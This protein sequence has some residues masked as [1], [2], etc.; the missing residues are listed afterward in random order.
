MNTLDSLFD[1]IFKNDKTVVYGNLGRNSLVLYDYI[2]KEMPTLAIQVFS[3]YY[4]FPNTHTIKTNADSIEKCDL[5]IYIEPPKNFEI[6]SHKHVARIVLFTSHLLL[7]DSP[8][9]YV[10]FYYT[11]DLRK[12]INNNKHIFKLQLCSLETS[13]GDVLKSQ[14]DYY[15]TKTI[16]VNFPVC[17]ININQGKPTP[18]LD[19]KTLLICD[20]TNTISPLNSYVYLWDI[21]DYIKDNIDMIEKWVICFPERRMKQYHQFVQDVRNK[22]MCKNIKI[23]NVV[24]K[25]DMLA[26]TPFYQIS[27]ID[28]NASCEV[29]K[30]CNLKYITPKNDTE[31]FMCSIKYNLT[32]FAGH[33]YLIK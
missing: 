31:A 18:P 30:F 1:F 13:R 7:Q 19:K 15:E 16:G 4:Y 22:F 3:N 29:K 11:P 8:A 20:L 21:L 28:I 2:T 17:D 10:S 26:L 23:G 33:A 6:I 32:P 12:S 25:N 5:L 27:K 14:F 9:T 24:N